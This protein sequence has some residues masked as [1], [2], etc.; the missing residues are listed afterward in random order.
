MPTTDGAQFLQVE[1]D[2]DSIDP[3]LHLTS[4]EFHT[5]FYA[6]EQGKKILAKLAAPLEQK[7]ADYNKDLVASNEAVMK[8]YKDRYRNSAL[9]SLRLLIH[10]ECLLWWRDKAGIKARIAQDLLMGIIAGT[11]FWQ[12][13]EEVSSVLGILFQSMLFVSIGAM[14][15]VAPQYAVR[16]VLYKHQD[17]NFFPTWTFIIGRSVASIPA[18]I[19]DGLLYG[20]IVYWFVGLA[21]NDGASF[22]NYVMFV[23]ITMVSSTGIGLLFSIFSAVTKDR[24]TGQACMSVSLVLLILFSG[25]TVRHITII[26]IVLSI[27]HFYS[28]FHAMLTRCLVVN[29]IAK[30]YSK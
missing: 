22:G 29:V 16:G 17:A 24:S 20:T 25:F 7:V 4:D 27:L 13:W 6:S 19:I 5:K 21:Y 15:K 28:L 10:R 26:T 18:S 30:G 1:Y 3:D 12:G 23:L 8:L 2:G 11:V 9:A 14:M